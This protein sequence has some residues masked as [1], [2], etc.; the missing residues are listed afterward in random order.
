VVN[1]EMFITGSRVM[2]F[3]SYRDEDL[4]VNERACRIFVWDWKTG[5]LVRLVRF[6]ES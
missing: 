5:G 1:N 6:D 3:C 2:M 4:P